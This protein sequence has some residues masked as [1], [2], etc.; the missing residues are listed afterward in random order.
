MFDK[1][2]IPCYTDN[3]KALAVFWQCCEAKFVPVF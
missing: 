1:S 2:T 3:K